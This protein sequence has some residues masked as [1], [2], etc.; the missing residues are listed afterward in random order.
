VAEETKDPRDLKKR[1]PSKAA[2]EA[3]EHVRVRDHGVRTTARV[4]RY[5]QETLTSET[6]KEAHRLAE[7]DE[8][9]DAKGNESRN[10]GAGPNPYGLQGV[11]R[12][13]GKRKVDELEKELDEMGPNVDRRA[14]TSYLESARESKASDAE[15]AVP[16]ETLTDTG[17]KIVDK[18]A[19]VAAGEK[20]V[21]PNAA[22]RHGTTADKVEAGEDYAIATAHAEATA[23]AGK[24]DLSA[25]KNPGALYGRDYRESEAKE[26]AE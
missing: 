3:P 11:E 5:D 14:L 21:L 2:N 17:S 4:D 24:D 10:T 25:D 7:G 26:S 16:G 19:R 13:V 9:S 1:P 23:E 6:Q 22:R 12:T 20:A 8:E 18:P 15:I